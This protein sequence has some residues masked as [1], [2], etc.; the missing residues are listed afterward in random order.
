MES[1]QSA[2]IYKDYKKTQKLID[3]ASASLAGIRENSALKE[4]ADKMR[5]EIEQI[6]A[7]VKEATAVKGA[8]PTKK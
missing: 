8:V 3:D 5:E 2:L 4:Q 1:A 6:Q 7:K